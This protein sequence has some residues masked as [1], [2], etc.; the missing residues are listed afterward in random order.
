MIDPFVVDVDF[1]ITFNK[2]TAWKD[3]KGRNCDNCFLCYN[4]CDVYIKILIDGKEVFR[5]ETKWDTSEPTF[6]STYQSKLN[7]NARITIEM[8]DDDVGD[9]PDDLMSKWDNLTVESLR[10]N[11]E[12]LEGK[13]WDAQYQNKI[14]YSTSC[15][16]WM[17]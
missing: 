12:H 3:V 5:T 13:L 17:H 11:H 16:N 15:R 8:W 7:K 2:G 9:T 4:H 14:E 10:N 1:S 6:G